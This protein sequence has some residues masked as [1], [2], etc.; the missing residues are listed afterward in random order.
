MLFAGRKYGKIRVCATHV[1]V[2]TFPF[3]TSTRSE[4]TLP[5]MIPDGESLSRSDRIKLWLLYGTAHQGEAR[6]L[7]E[8][9]GGN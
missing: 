8:I 6:N 3:N 9:Q 2:Q 5:A 4:T 7:E 1:P